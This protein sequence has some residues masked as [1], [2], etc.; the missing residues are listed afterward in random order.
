MEYIEGDEIDKFEPDFL[1]D[2]KW[3]DIF[4][5]VISAFEYLEQNHILHRD[6]RPANIMI[7][8]DCNVKIIDFGFG[9]QLD[10]TKNEKNSILL[11]WP[12]T[13][14]PNEIQ[15]N[16]EY[17]TR[18]EIYFVGALFKNLIKDYSDYFNY[19]HILEKMTKTNPTQRY[20]SFTEILSDISV[21]VMSEIDFTDREKEIYQD[22]ADALTYHIS[23]YSDKYMPVNDILL[24]IT[25]L[26]ELIRNS[27]LEKY[28]QNNN[29]LINCFIKGGFT[30]IPSKNIEVEVVKDFYEFIKNL[31]SHKQKV[32]AD[33]INSRL[34]TIRIKIEEDDLPF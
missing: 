16:D 7:D 32:V 20:D 27:A 8:R 28:I 30:Y 17:D 3:N 15:N 13:E 21:G 1:D 24:T 31:T 29:E 2:K 33:N 19:N 11:N 25:G 34:S 18:T 5:E 9:K 14:M 26:E 12:V 10:G 23:S 22:F 4:Y 6:V